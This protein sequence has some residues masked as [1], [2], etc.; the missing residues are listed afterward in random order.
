MIRNRVVWWIIGG[1][2]IIT[3]VGWFSPRGGCD[4]VTTKNQVGSLNGEPVT[5]AELRLARFNSYMMLCMM[6]GR[7]IPITTEVDK[8]LRDQ[9]WRRLA[10]LRMAAKLG[11]TTTTDEVLETIRQDPQFQANG[12]FSRSRYEA[13]ER[14]VL[15]NLGASAAQFE[16]QLHETITLQKLQNLTA[17]AAWI[18]PAEMQKTVA[19]Y[20]DVFSVQSVV[21][22]SN[23][24]PADVKVT[25]GEARR[26]F[27][28]NTNLFVIP[29]KVALKVVT[30][31]VSE[32]LAKAH[33]DNAAVE[34]Y[35]DTHTD[36]FSTTD[37]NGTKS[38]TPIEQVRGTISNKLLHVSAVDEARNAAATFS[39]ALAPGRDG[40]ATSFEKVAADRGL[41]VTTTPL[42]AAG[43]KIPGLETSREFFLTAF[44]L[45][46]TPDDYFSDPVAAS[47]HVYVLAFLT[48]TDA[49]VPEFDEVRAEVMPHAV[50][51]AREDLLAKKAAAIRDRFQ[52]ALNN[53]KTLEEAARAEGLNVSTT[54]TFS[55]YTAPDSLGTREILEDITLR[56]SGELSAVLTTTNGLLIAYIS[57]RKPAGKDESDVVRSQVGMNIIRRRARTLF[58]EW[59]NYLLRIGNKQDT[60]APKPVADVPEDAG[61]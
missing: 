46:P 22:A 10:A 7:Q 9:A 48:N 20:A 44:R 25:D 61:L 45:R 31:P 2:V 33:T 37:T 28:A 50:E 40:T 47:N 57:D 55:V 49:R 58:S 17:C 60:A 35:Y 26:F 14:G 56:N 38:I 41:T 16:E 42:F 39:E 19:R 36:E 34:E 3:F 54:M 8:E 29:D 32:Y 11:I 6:V 27:D 13:F 51:K 43:E 15:A 53:R 4:T 30:Y 1:I 5:D 24:V 18:S 23:L 52:S 21:I 59:E 12:A